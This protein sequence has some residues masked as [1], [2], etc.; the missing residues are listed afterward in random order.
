MHRS[1]EWMRL[2]AILLHIVLLVLVMWRRCNPDD[3]D[4]TVAIL[5]QK[6]SQTNQKL[7]NNKTK[8][9]KL[10]KTYVRRLA[11]DVFSFAK[12]DSWQF[13]KKKTKKIFN[14]KHE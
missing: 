10:N 12:R 1:K 3:G 6:S 8:T 5:L 7:I 4:A 13:I 11:L 14:K 2:D 9:S